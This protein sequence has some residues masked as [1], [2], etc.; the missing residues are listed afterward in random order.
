MGDL[1]FSL[2]REEKDVRAHLLTFLG[3]GGD[4][5]RGGALKGASVGVGVE[6]AG[7]GDMKAF[8]VKNGRL[9]VHK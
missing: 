1:D 3:G 5:Y 8:G 7:G 6:E 2:T 9:E 4:H